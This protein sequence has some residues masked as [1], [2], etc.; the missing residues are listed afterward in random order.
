MPENQ[1]PDWTGPLT[2]SP[3]QEQPRPNSG[4]LLSPADR[5]MLKVAQVQL[6]GAAEA[7][8]AVLRKL[9]PGGAG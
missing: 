6:R 1:P 3:N 8:A 2:P 4:M 7:L 5:R 9:P